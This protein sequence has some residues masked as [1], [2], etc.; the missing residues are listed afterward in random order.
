MTTGNTVR[1]RYMALLLLVAGLWIS[2]TPLASAQTG[3]DQ[4]CPPMSGTSPIGTNNFPYNNCM[5][6]KYGPAAADIVVQQMDQTGKQKQFSNF[7]SCK[8]PSGAPTVAYGLCFYSGPPVATG[9]ASNPPLPCVLSGDKQSAECVCYKMTANSASSP[10][11]IDINAI[12]NLDVYKQ[13]VATCGHNGLK[14]TGSS[15]PAA[16]ACTAANNGTLI[17]GSPVISAFVGSKASNYAPASGQ[18]PTTACKSGLYAGCMTAPC[19]DSG[20]TDPKGN[21]LVTCRCPTYTG[22]YEVGVP[23]VSC[24]PNTMKPPGIKGSGDFTFVWSA[25]HTVQSTSNPK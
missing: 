22:P 12:L 19:V 7:L 25:S 21:P 4:V 24:D 14:C 11:Y 20:K 6:T 1:R 16:P 5:T 9:A 18:S 2:G 15:A 10:Y 3:K 13:T 23:G 17:P 8:V